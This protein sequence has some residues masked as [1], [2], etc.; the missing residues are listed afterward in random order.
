M[1]GSVWFWW[2]GRSGGEML[3]CLTEVLTVFFG[4]S[5]VIISVSIMAHVLMHEN[6]SSLYFNIVIYIKYLLETYG[7]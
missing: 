5:K 6:Y 2:P 7:V 1:H 4:R 3:R